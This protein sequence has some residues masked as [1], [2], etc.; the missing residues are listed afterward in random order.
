[1]ANSRNYSVLNGKLNITGT[2]IE[3]HREKA[4]LSRQS[5]SNKLMIMGFDISANSLYDIETAKRTVVDYEICAIAKALDIPV[6]S[7]LNDYY[8]S[9]ENT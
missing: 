8:N 3:Q 9:I 5:L 4:K 7:L 1:M 2:K 6:Q